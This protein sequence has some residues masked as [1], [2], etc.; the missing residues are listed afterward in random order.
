MTSALQKQDK[1]LLSKRL[2]K[3]GWWRAE[4]SGTEDVSS[5]I[6]AIAVVRHFH[7]QET[8]SYCQFVASC[9]S[10]PGLGS[11]NRMQYLIARYRSR[12]CWIVLERGYSRAG[13][14]SQ[15]PSM[16]SNLFEGR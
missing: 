4:F 14:G 15:A 12:T 8:S 16:V 2:G 6:K 5:Q 11:R 3:D 13:G 7:V 1:I 10:S 9:W